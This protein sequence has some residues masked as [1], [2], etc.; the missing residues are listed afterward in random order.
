MTAIPLSFGMALALNG[1]FFA[2]AAVRKTD[3]VTDL[4]YSL[5]F[6]LL[7][8]F[9]PLTGAREPVQLVASLLVVIWAARLGTYL[10][11]GRTLAWDADLESKIAALTPAQVQGAMKRHIT[12][13]SI[14]IVKAGDFAKAAA[15]PS[16][17]VQ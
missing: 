1:A 14:S 10:F 8:V 6:A 16:G 12:A 11:R 3:L 5:T 15:P 7:A 4:S 2:V 9:L 13:S 17:P